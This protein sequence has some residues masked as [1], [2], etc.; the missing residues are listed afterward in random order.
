MR[1]QQGDVLIYQTPDDG[2][3]TVERG[4][5]ELSAGLESAAYLSLFGGNEEDDGREGN[6][7]QW[8]GNLTEERPERRYRSETQHLLRSIPPIP[9]N[10]RRIEEAAGRDLAWFVTVG[11]ASSVSVSASMP[12]LNKVRLVVKFEADAAPPALEFIENWKAAT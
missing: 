6:R 4:L 10:L 3:I 5:V 12:G 8:W 7:Q 9:A 1:Q 2:D 11:A